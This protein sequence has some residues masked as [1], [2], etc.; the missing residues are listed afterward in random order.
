MAVASQPQHEQP[1]TEIIESKMTRPVELEAMPRPR[2][3]G[4]AC[5]VS[6]CFRWC[7]VLIASED[8]FIGGR[9]A[10]RTVHYDELDGKELT[11]AVHGG[12][13][14]LQSEGACRGAIRR[15]LMAV[16]PRLMRYEGGHR[17]E[18]CQW[19][20]FVPAGL[21]ES[22]VAGAAGGGSYACHVWMHVNLTS[23]YD[24]AR[25][26]LLS[27]EAAEAATDAA[28]RRASDGGAATCPICMEELSGGGR[29]T[30]LAGC[31]HAF[32]R[33]C[34]LEWFRTGPTCPSC[35]RDMMQYLDPCARAYMTA[36]P[37]IDAS[38][39]SGG[40]VL[41]VCNFNISEEDVDL[42]Q[43]AICS[44]SSELLISIL[45]H[46]LDEAMM[47]TLLEGINPGHGTTFL[48]LRFASRMPS[49][50]GI[51]AT[52]DAHCIL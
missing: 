27:C 18:E 13:A 22:I 1:V 37:A 43:F 10:R 48:V 14:A 16:L 7:S 34:I 30:G 19:D 12:P 38:G 41:L 21:V 51:H 46:Y 26:L 2:G 17:T 50:V 32:H 25:A 6:V 33:G 11:L 28:A 15:M 23:V 3:Q 31:S 40:M 8:L 24:E 42:V 20:E 5:T 45:P 49:A 52:V 9:R 36:V 35:R 4:Q 39:C 44:S 47:L 29:V